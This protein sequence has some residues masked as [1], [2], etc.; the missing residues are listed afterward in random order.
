MPLASG[1]PAPR[2]ARHVGLPLPLPLAPPL[3]ALPRP[4][5]LLVW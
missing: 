1:V 5:L 2:A 4:P 3:S